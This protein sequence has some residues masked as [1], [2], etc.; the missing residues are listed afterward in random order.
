MKGFDVACP[1]CG[2]ATEVKLDLNSLGDA[3]CGSCGEDFGVK[4]AV[5]VFEQRAAQWKK[6]LAWVELAKS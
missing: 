5:R 3:S 2:E 1:K 4:E 6:V